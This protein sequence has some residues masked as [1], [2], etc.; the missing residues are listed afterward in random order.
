MK[1]I[2]LFLIPLLLF[3]KEFK[4]KSTDIDVVISETTAGITPSLIDNQSLSFE[5]AKKIFEKINMEFEGQKREFQSKILKLSIDASYLHRSI[6]EK[7]SEIESLKSLIS[8]KEAKLEQLRADIEAEQLFISQLKNLSEKDIE[9]NSNISTQGYFISFVENR[10][11]VSRD[12]FIQSATNAILEKSIRTI[13]GILVNSISKFDKELSITIR[14][15]SSGTAITDS[16]DNDIKIFFSKSRSH[17]VLIYGTKVD[18]YPFERGE[19]IFQRNRNIDGKVRYISLIRTRSDIDKVVSEIAKRYPKL[20]FD[21]ESFYSK[22]ESALE[23]IEKHNRESR[24]TIL[25]LN[26]DHQEFIS[27]LEKRI[28]ARKKVVAILQQHKKLVGEEISDLT[29]DLLEAQKSKKEL[30]E[31]FKVVQRDIEELKSSILFTKAEMFDR[32]HSNAVKETRE[33]VKELIMDID[34]SIA[35]TSQMMETLFNGSEILKDITDEVEYE[36]IYLKSIVIPYFVQNTDR[37][38]AL[39]TLEVQFRD[40]KLPKISPLE[41]MEFVKIS[42][43]KFIFG[44][45]NGDFDEKPT[46]EI[47]IPKDFYIS[48]YETTI[49]EYMEFAKATQSHYPEWYRNRT[50]KKY[51]NICFDESCPIV[52]ISWEDATAF[53]EWLSKRDGKKYRLPTEFE[54]EYVAKGDL[55]LDYGFLY[56][57]LEDYSWFVKNSN[58]TTHRVG[59]KKP[60]LFGVYDMQ[61]NVWE[62]CQDSYHVDYMDKR[63]DKYKVIRGGD[64]RTRKYYLR[65]SNRAKYLKNKKSNGIGFRLVQEIE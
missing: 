64:W 33:I 49:G 36:K 25:E 32:R 31:R 61:G 1:W 56:G 34:K 24:K 30:E 59:L 27:K 46:K 4:F 58:G 21:R 55:N 43:G 52:G 50:M 8:R 65:S 48:K 5:E 44:S 20:E 6:K 39:V 45:E 3:S 18:V 9:F 60:N 47:E 53:A 10:R 54:W 13:N 63:E 23:A 19:I 37:T 40:K 22:I 16:S 14:E 12:K 38:G 42:K 35:K 51:R 41:K 62:F 29:I 26:R 2:G 7:E 17:S 28:E 57:K 15:T 11:S